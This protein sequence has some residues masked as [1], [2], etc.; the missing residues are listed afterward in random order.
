MESEVRAFATALY[1]ISPRW[2]VSAGGAIGGLQ[3]DAA[4]SPIVEGDSYSTAN[5]AVLYRF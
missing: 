1:T 2:I 5:A 4:D 3:G